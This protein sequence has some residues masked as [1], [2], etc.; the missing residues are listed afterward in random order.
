VRRCECGSCFLN[1]EW[2][3]GGSFCDMTILL[4]AALLPH[5]NS[6]Q[7][8]IEAESARLSSVRVPESAP[9]CA[10]AATLSSQPVI[11]ATTLEE[12]LRRPHVHYP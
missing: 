12:L 9:V 8:R 11:R 4:H 5:P 1:G 10:E 3:E 2:G 6:L 7:A